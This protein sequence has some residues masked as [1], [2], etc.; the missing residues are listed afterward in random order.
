MTAPPS[1]PI[2][3][4]QTPTPRRLAQVRA[5]WECAGEEPPLIG[6]IPLSRELVGLLRRDDDGG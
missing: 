1:D 2:H 4:P 6:G 5:E 3:N